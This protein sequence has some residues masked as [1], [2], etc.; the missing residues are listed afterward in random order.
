MSK[1]FDDASLAMIPSAYKDGKLYSIRPTDGDGDF[2][3]SR[4]SNLAA[5]RVD[6]NGL[7]EKGRENLL[8]YSNDITNAAWLKY[9]TSVTSGHASYN[10]GNTAFKLIPNTGVTYHRITQ[11][12]SWSNDV[13]TASFYAKADGYN[14]IRLV[15]YTGA[16]DIIVGVDLT[17]GSIVSETGSTKIATN[18]ESVGNEWY[19]ISLTASGSSVT[20]VYS[21]Q[22]YIHE[23]AALTQNWA[24]DGTSGVLFADPQREL[25]LVATDYIET[26]SSTAQAGILEDM[27]RLD[28]SGGASCPA[29]LLEPQRTNLVEQSEYFSN[30]SNLSSNPVDVVDNFAISPEGCAKCR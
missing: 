11:T 23:D 1:L 26:T 30:W 15:T 27:P 5:T 3:F 14:F 29:L 6:V 2:T 9:S 22:V 19:R 4:G 17:D 7:I 10:G 12:Q 21:F 8:L 25:G 13:R 18:V 20:S 16:T 28:Y 24:G